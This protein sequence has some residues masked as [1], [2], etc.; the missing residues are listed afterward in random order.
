MNMGK[1]SEELLYENNK[2]NTLITSRKVLPESAA[3]S[4]GSDY[5]KECKTV[6]AMC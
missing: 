5:A 4:D 1:R 2:S 3:E 6:K